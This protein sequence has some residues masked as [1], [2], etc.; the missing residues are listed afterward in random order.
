MPTTGAALCLH[1]ES[2]VQEAVIPGRLVQDPVNTDQIGMNIH[3][4]Y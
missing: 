3:K 1:C 2:T 4:R